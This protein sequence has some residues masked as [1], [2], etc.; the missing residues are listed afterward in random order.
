[1]EARTMDLLLLTRL[2]A[3][4]IVWGKWVSLQTQTLL[5]A[6][7]LLPYAIVRYFFGSV[8]LLG[9]F[10]IMA[11]LG[12][13]GAVLT[14]VGLWASGLPKPL[15][16]GITALATLT[17]FSAINVVVMSMRMGGVSFHG[18]SPGSSL[19]QWL[20][21]GMA[22]WGGLVLLGYALSLA[23]RWFAPPAENHAIWPRLA[24]L[25]LALPAPLIAWTGNNE[26]A[27]IQVM[28]AL[29]ALG[30]VAAI[31]LAGTRDVMAI[32]LR[33]W[34]SRERRRRLW[35][36][37]LPGWPSACAWLA[38]MLIAALA[39]LAAVDVIAARDLPMGRA[40][41]LGVLAWSGL[42]FPALLV[43]LL[44]TAGRVSGMLYFILHGLLGL[45]AVMAGSD[46]LGRLASTPMRVL[47]WIAHAVPT[48]SF[49]HALMEFGNPSALPSVRFG[50]ACGVAVT[51]ALMV[52]LARPYWSRVRAY[53]DG[54]EE[55][56]R[57]ES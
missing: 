51:V 24:P 14:G 28:T 27:G 16:F 17:L 12:M 15:R 45:F 8:D 53:R 11:A 37:F 39:M 19:G 48:A 52:R 4:R 6:T 42:V 38:A 18:T 29:V 36:I 22:A 41:W 2:D 55:A 31:E 21:W 33:D 50:Q 10:A 35:P 40:A 56:G 44:P 34:M 1:M 3:W 5:M 23:V 13:G 57:P 32:H 30:V 9:D 7:T 26:L 47:D 54:A 49:W 43:A 20:S 25:A 46:G